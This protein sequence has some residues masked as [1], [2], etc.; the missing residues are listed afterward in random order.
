MKDKSV[1]T[2]SVLGGGHGGIAEAAYLSL[3]G[4]KVIL[5]NRTLKNI[6]AIEQG[7]KLKGCLNG[8]A[9]IS[10]VTDDLKSAVE[11]AK[12][13][14]IILPAYAH[15]DIL[16]KM[17]DHLIDGQILVLMPGKLGGGLEALHIL[18]EVNKNITIFET[19]SVVIGARR[20]GTDQVYIHGIK[21]SVKIGGVNIL[22]DRTR[23]MGDF[24]LLKAIHSEF[25]LVNNVM[26]ASFSE[27]GCVLH[28][29]INLLNVARIESS[30]K[31]LFYGEGVTL[32]VAK[33]INALDLERINVAYA[34]GITIEPVSKTT[35]RYYRSRSDNIISV[36]RTTD[37]YK[38]VGSPANIDN[39]FFKE[40]VLV[41]L[42]LYK[43]L[44]CLAGINVPVMDSIITLTECMCVMDCHVIQRNFTDLGYEGYKYL[45]LKRALASLNI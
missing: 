43:K 35:K 23:I 2:I 40:D 20:L 27:V 10:K 22:R 7:V 3:H 12:V 24:K 14:F 1:I 9:H 26:E 39:R 25:A 37:T 5:F 29:V 44:A 4:H 19:E 32:S 42:G 36:L 17:R 8:T 30:H 41:S 13:I 15:K 34:Y 16:Y 21:C 45:Q 11:Y 18:R 6:I 28:P 31:F 33:V 38:D